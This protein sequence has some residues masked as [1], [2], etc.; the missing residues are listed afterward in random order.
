ML[1]RRVFRTARSV[2]SASVDSLFTYPA[3]RL[4]KLP[5]Q[6]LLLRFADEGVLIT[7]GLLLVAVNIIIAKD[8]VSK[9]NSFAA[10]ALSRHANRNTALYTKL[11]STTTTINTGNGLIATAQA[12]EQLEAPA[13]QVAGASIT[14]SSITKID[15]EGLSA[16]IPDSIRPLINNQVRIYQTKPGD[17]LASIAAQYGVNINTIKWANNLTSDDIKDGWYLAIPTVNGVL[18]KTDS[19][20]TIGDIARKFKCSEERIIAFN[21]LS[22]PD[23]FDEDQ[24]LMCPDG[25]LP[26]PPKPAPTAPKPNKRTVGVAYSDVPDE[27]G[28]THVFVWGNCTWYVARRMKITFGGHA[29]YWLKN[30]AAAGYE[31]GKVPR[32]GSAVVVPS[33]SPYG[34]VAYVESVNGDGTM[35]I[36]EMNV[37]GLGVK[38][39][40]TMPV[41]EAKG[42]IYPKY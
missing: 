25:Q 42:F 12:D 26:A 1:S 30:A 6:K 2:T 13:G 29:K 11:F 17:T 35:T 14:N 23:D 24:Y 15:S 40:R 3:T 4:A 27:A 18:V 16:D 31:T 39:S 21:G 5:W 19:N 22:G 36:S 41:S 10:T 28:S 7:L 20:T 37:K 33:S 8:G 38:S 9:D 32:V 34:H